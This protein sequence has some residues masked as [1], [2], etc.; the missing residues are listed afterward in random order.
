VNSAA[1]PH[2]DA[3]AALDWP[4]VSQ[5]LESTLAGLGTPVLL[6]ASDAPVRQR[7]LLNAQPPE[8]FFARFER[9][10]RPRLYTNSE[11][12]LSLLTARLASIAPNL[13]RQIEVAKN[14]AKMREALASLYPDLRFRTL[15]IPDLAQLDDPADLPFPLVL[16]PSI[17]FF[18]IGV[19]VVEDASGW[20]AGRDALLAAMAGARGAFPES[21]LGGEQILLEELIAGEEFAVDA[22]F[23]AAGQP[24]ILNIMA[25]EFRDRADTSDLLYYTSAELMRARLPQFTPI[26]SQMGEVFGFR[27]FP[28][29][30]E[31][32]VQEAGSKSGEKARGKG[33][34]GDGRGATAVPI[35]INPLRFAG[36]CTTDLVHH[37]FGLNSHRAFLLEEGP[38]WDGILGGADS[39]AGGS[40]F[41][42]VIC[43]LPSTLD[44]TQIVG[45]DWDGLESLFRHPLEIRRM[46][47]RRFPVLAMA[48]VESRDLAELRSLFEVDF[49]GFVRL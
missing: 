45:V 44:R 35:E 46:D 40:V 27:D 24:V 16:K 34:G 7:G 42:L 30:I 48:I 49:T 29:H 31:F 26:L 17:G 32:R 2:P 3:F 28:A 39:G 21:V 33:L 13:V 43:A 22:Y 47:Y 37:A 9:S 41:C 20:A 38:D 14:K 36:F 8:E 15:S 12:T 4:Y 18:S 1:P 5:L 25:H 11:N 10:P 6:T 23:D 19:T